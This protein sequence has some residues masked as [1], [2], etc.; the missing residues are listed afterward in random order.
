MTRSN[1]L[2]PFHEEGLGHFENILPQI[3]LW[4][5]QEENSR[6]TA[7]AWVYQISRIANANWTSGEVVQPRSVRA[8]V[9]TCY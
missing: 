5:R 1:P 2:D 9:L 6:L 4:G 3:S 7:I 8:V